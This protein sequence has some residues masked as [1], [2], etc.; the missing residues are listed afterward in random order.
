MNGSDFTNSRS[1]MPNSTT[2]HTI[3]IKIIYL[4][5]KSVPLDNLDQTRAF[6]LKKKK[7]LN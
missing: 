3:T 5:K 6:S 2:A 7:T 1:P 4:K